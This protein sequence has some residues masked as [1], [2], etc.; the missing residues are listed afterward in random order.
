MQTEE[1]R[2][3][4]DR[5]R[6]AAEAGTRGTPLPRLLA[7][8]A[9]PCQTTRA[10]T[11]R[12][13]SAAPPGAAAAAGG[14]T[15]LPG[16]S[17]VAQAAAP[18]RRAA[19][20]GSPPPGNSPR[21]AGGAGRA[22]SRGRPRGGEGGSPGGGRRAGGLPWGSAALARSPSALA[23]PPPSGP[24]QQWLRGCRLRP[25]RA[26]PGDICEVQPSQHNSL[27]KYAWNC[28]RGSPEFSNFGTR[29][30]RPQFKCPEMGGGGAGEAQ[31]F[32]GAFSFRSICDYLEIQK[33]KGL[34]L[35]R[36]NIRV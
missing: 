11:R 29:G 23:A 33:I 25:A 36:L 35:S 2:W 19:R 1:L 4:P 15:P 17:G 26:G 30:T 18:L 6:P 7:A 22:P 14:G 12:S 9:P 34:L 20:G 5:A 10:G 24:R 13:P 16:L 8:D 27:G 3:G 28:K 32:P 31:A 21:E